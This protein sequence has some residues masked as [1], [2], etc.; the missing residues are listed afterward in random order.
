VKFVRRLRRR[1][2]VNEGYVKA[3][4]RAIL[5]N[6]FLDDPA[7]LHPRDAADRDGWLS[8]ADEVIAAI[9]EGGE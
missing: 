7:S 3:E 9:N 2:C 8:T 5:T 4:D 1:W 6:W